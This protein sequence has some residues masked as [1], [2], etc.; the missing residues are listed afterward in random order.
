A[1]GRRPGFF[2]ASGASSALAYRI[3]SGPREPR[4]VQA[5]RLLPEKHQQVSGSVFLAL[6]GEL[7]GQP[8]EEARQ[9][10]GTIE[11]QSVPVH[12]EPEGM[13]IERGEQLHEGLQSAGVAFE[14]S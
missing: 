10:I 3:G 2:I 4:Q 6:G 7:A 13:G 14:Q 8:L 1:V 11:T 9:V 5:L 12:A